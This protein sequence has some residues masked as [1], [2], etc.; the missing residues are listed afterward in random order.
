[1]NFILD[2]FDEKFNLLFVRTFFLILLYD[3]PLTSIIS[4][5]EY[6]EKPEFIMKYKEPIH[7][8]KVF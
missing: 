2:F 6:Y 5:M 1:M 3:I 8:E 4:L 7:K